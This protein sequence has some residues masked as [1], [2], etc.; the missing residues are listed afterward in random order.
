MKNTLLV[1]LSLI[2]IVFSSSAFADEFKRYENGWIAYV[3][4]IDPFD[5]SKIK[6]EEIYKGDFIFDCRNINM[7]IG[8][9]YYSS[10]SS[11]SKIK[12]IV[13]ERPIVDK[14]GTYSSYHSGNDMM[15][16]SSYY[17]FKLDFIDVMSFKDGR[18]LKFAGKYGKNG[19]KN[20]TLNLT[21]FKSMFDKMCS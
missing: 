8:G 5:S 16:D 1:L 14:R 17:S 15:N 13:D 10:F 21:G 20:K 19:W 18:T 9:E 12:Y 6:I 3:K 11:P 4:V 2:M 7:Q